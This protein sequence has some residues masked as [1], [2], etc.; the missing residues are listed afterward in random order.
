[1]VFYCRHIV[2]VNRNEEILDPLVTD[3]TEDAWVIFKPSTLGP[4]AGEG[5]FAKDTIPENMVFA[6]FGGIRISDGDWNAKRK[7]LIDPLYWLRLEDASEVIYLPD[8]LGRDTGKYRATL[9]HKINHSF[10]HWNCFFHDIEH[11]R[12]GTIRAARSTEPIPEGEEILCNYQMQYNEAAPWYQELWRRE[13]DSDT[14]YGPFGTRGGKRNRS[15]PIEPMLSD[16]DVYKDFY[17]H[18]VETLNLEV[19][20]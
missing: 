1:M 14:T 15:E 3:S 5:L 18:A 16:H 2:P 8:S 19:L 10:T 9:A 6:Y 13:I 4:H 17:R 11:P 7:S 20:T 12:L